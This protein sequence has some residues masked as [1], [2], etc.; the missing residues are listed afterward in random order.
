MAKMG[1]KG[2]SKYTK[3][4]VNNLA[5]HLLEYVSN[6]KFPTE[7]E[8]CA[9]QHVGIQRL[10]EFANPNHAS[11]NST[12]SE[13]FKEFKNIQHYKWLKLAAEGSMPPAIFIFFAKNVLGMRDEQHIKGDGLIRN[14]LVVMRP[15]GKNSDI[16][17]L[18]AAAQTLN[19]DN[20]T[21]I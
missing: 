8:F 11:Y 4:F 21:D 12:F 3:E 9:L 20:H 15:D 17:G 1:P 5:S 16:R 2:P 6:E 19:A 7:Q 10:T 18:F 13:A 14:T